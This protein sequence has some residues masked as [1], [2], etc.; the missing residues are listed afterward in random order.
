MLDRN[1]DDERKHN[2]N[3]EALLAGRKHKHREKPFHLFA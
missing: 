3:D 1:P 2:E